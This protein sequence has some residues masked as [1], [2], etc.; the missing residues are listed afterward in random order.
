[1]PWASLGAALRRLLLA[2]IRLVRK[3]DNLDDTQIKDTRSGLLQ[4]PQR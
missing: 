4:G 3:S 1:M 2:P